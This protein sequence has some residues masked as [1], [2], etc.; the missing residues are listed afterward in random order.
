VPAKDVPYAVT[1]K[2]IGQELGGVPLHE[3]D[4]RKQWNLRHGVGD[5]GQSVWLWAILALVCAMVSAIGCLD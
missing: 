5:L 3:Q 4:K 1:A 2:A